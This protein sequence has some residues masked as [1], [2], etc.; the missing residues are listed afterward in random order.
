MMWAMMLCCALPII[1]IVLAGGAGSTFG[2]STWLVIAAVGLMVV[3]HYLMG[4]HHKSKSSASNE[5]I[6]KDPVCGMN[7]DSDISTGFQGKLYFFCAEHCKKE[8]N[9]EPEL[10]A[11]H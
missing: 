1:L 8:F 6:G 4:R 5:K 10:Y 2:V 7:G 11:T 3:C 9:K